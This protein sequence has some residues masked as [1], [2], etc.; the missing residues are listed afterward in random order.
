VEGL[1]V[2]KLTLAVLVAAVAA[3]GAVGGHKPKPACPPCQTGF[4]FLDSPAFST[5]TVRRPPSTPYSPQP[6]DMVFATDDVIFLRTGHVLAGA[7]MPTHSAIFFRKPDGE[8]AILEAG[9]FNSGHIGVLEPL[10]HLRAYEQLGTVWVRPRCCPLTE[11]QSCRLTQFAVGQEGKRFAWCKMY[12]L[13]TPFR[14]RGPIRTYFLAKPQ[15]PEGEKFYCAELVTESIVFAGLIDATDARPAATFPSDLF[16]DGRKN[17]FLKHH[18]K[19]SER[20][21][22][23]PARWSSCPFPCAGCTPAGNW[24]IG[25]GR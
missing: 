1:A 2:R 9:P 8:L 17:P 12:A 23:V 3:T 7:G 18:F 5:D 25:V 14:P 19:L 13:I 22:G 15:G 10:E 4:G 11:E 6:G 24:S 21:W 16:F 20:G